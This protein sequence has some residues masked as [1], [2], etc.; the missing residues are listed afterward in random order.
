MSFLLSQTVQ[1]QRSISSTESFGAALRPVLRR[2]RHCLMKALQSSLWKAWSSVILIKNNQKPQTRPANQKTFP[3][4]LS[5]TPNWQFWICSKA[6]V[7]PK[8]AVLFW[9]KVTKRASSVSQPALWGLLLHLLGQTW[10]SE[11]RVTRRTQ[12]YG[13]W[14]SEQRQVWGHVCSTC[15]F[16]AF[17]ASWQA[18][19]TLWAERLLSGRNGTAAVGA[20]PRTGP[21]VPL[22]WGHSKG[23]SPGCSLTSGEGLA[24]TSAEAP[25]LHPYNW[26]LNPVFTNKYIALEKGGWRGQEKHV[27]KVV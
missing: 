9:D 26:H 4:I 10:L 13:R 16:P 8:F 23:W 25:E 11:P 15:F 17:P 18:A 1:N 3:Q 6:H 24:H 19:D 5:Q 20:G 7:H 12:L 21:L 14:N 2:V 22:D 27:H